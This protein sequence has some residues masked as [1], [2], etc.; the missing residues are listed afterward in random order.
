MYAPSGDIEQPLVSTEIHSDFRYR[1]NE[2]RYCCNRLTK[3]WYILLLL[4]IVA[5]VLTTIALLLI[6]VAGRALAQK[7]LNDSEITV[8]MSLSNPTSNTFDAAI[9][10]SV[11]NRGSADATLES[12]TITIQY[13]DDD[14]GTMN[15]PDIKASGGSVTKINVKTTMTVTNSAIFNKFSVALSTSEQVTLRMKA[16]LTAK[17]LGITYASLDFNKLVLID[18]LANLSTPPPEILSQSVVDGFNDTVVMKIQAEIFN[19]SSVELNDMGKLNFTVTYRDVVVG[20]SIT[21]TPVSLK[22]GVNALPQTVYVL[23]TSQNNDMITEILGAYTAGRD[24]Q[25]ILKGNDQS[26]TV[27]LLKEGLKALSINVTFVGLHHDEDKLFKVVY[28]SLGLTKIGV[29]ESQCSGTA[30]HNYV[31]VTIFAHNPLDVVQRLDSTVINIMW[32]GWTDMV[33]PACNISI[34]PLA[35]ANDTNMN[36]VL[37]PRSTRIRPQKLCIYD[38]S[39]LSRIIGWLTTCVSQIQSVTDPFTMF[40]ALNGTLTGV[41]GTY[42]TSIPYQQSHLL[43]VSQFSMV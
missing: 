3:G 6:F 42:Q 29:D 31:N 22:M 30:T 34:T 5:V 9:I 27:P 4:A 33:N 37:P 18:G 25:L 35:Y 1:H 21:D 41:A 11:D 23:R 39:V 14:F 38:M 43:T 20:Y 13:G 26:T 32:E 19:P 36:L 12:T 28:Q 7:Q 24:I 10:A 2:K 15:F 40:V 8:K 17:A 16:T